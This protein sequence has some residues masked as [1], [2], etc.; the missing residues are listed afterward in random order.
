[1]IQAPVGGNLANRLGW[2][3]RQRSRG[4]RVASFRDT[5]AGTNPEWRQRSRVRSDVSV[6]MRRKRVPKG[7]R[8]V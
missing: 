3:R 4:R 5:K 8:G 6:V 2:R 7:L 1:M